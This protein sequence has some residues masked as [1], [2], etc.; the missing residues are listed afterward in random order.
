M[1]VACSAHVISWLHAEMRTLKGSPWVY[2]RFCAR[3]SLVGCLEN[4]SRRRSGQRFEMHTI[5]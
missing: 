2:L 5:A 3:C 1:C 4:F